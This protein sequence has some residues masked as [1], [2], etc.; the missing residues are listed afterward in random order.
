MM[1]LANGLGRILLVSVVPLAVACGGATTRPPATEPVASTQLRGT[2]AGKDFSGVYGVA[3]K[4]LTFPEKRLI[5]IY[6][7]KESCTYGG[8]DVG[9]FLLTAAPWRAGF[10]EDFSFAENGVNATFVTREQGKPTDNV[11]STQGRIEIVEAPVT[12]GALGKVR[13]RARAVRDGTGTLD[14]VEGEVPVEFCD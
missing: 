3:K 1:K 13:L 6:E 9:P 7:T 2:V 11:V 12:V 5:A 4:D 14:T 10:G 8:P